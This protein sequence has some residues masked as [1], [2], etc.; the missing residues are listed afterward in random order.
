MDTPELER[1]DVNGIAPRDLLPWALYSF[2][3]HYAFRIQI[4]Y[5]VM[6][7][8]CVRDYTSLRLKP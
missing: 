3:M 7:I 1:G 2:V 4:G 8:L 6:D 5:N